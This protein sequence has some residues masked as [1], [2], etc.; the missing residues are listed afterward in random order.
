MDDTTNQGANPFDPA[1][2]GMPMGNY[3]STPTPPPQEEDTTPA[4]FQLGTLFVEP[5]KV[6]LPDSN[7]QYDSDYFVKLL[8]GSISLSRDEKK[9]IID[10]IPRLRQEQ[11]D[12]LTR[13]FEEEKLKFS[14]LS[15]KHVPQ[16][17]RLADQHYR[18]W[19]DIEA[20]A[21]QME[22]KSHD[23]EQADEIRKSLGL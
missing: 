11:I 23:D 2:G 6:R 21:A 1:N 4:N 12:E 17:E 16:L 8:A 15:K 18:E 7:L 5:I 19:M 10:S 22:K 13:I 9:R 14:M 20:E 3:G